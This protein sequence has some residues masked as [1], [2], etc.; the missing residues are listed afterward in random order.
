MKWL[1]RLKGKACGAAYWQKDEEMVDGFQHMKK[2]SE[3]AR[4]IMDRDFVDPAA[5][6]YSQ[7]LFVSTTRRS[8]DV[9]ACAL[10]AALEQGWSM[11]SLEFGTGSKAKGPRSFSVALA[12]GSGGAHTTHDCALATDADGR[13][14]LVPQGAVPATFHFAIGPNRLERRHGR[15]ANLAASAIRARR[16]LV[17]AARRTSA[18]G[19]FIEVHAL[20]AAA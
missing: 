12:D 19:A 11:V 1:S 5:G 16:D 7:T 4:R 13:Y 3:A 9:E 20:V 18:D 14:V 17:V 10:A 8:S 15:P 2:F 6:R